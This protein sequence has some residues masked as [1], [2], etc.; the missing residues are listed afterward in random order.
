[1]LSSPLHFVFKTN[2]L[3]ATLQ[4]KFFSSGV[5]II[6]STRKKVEVFLEWS[7]YEGIP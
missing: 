2:P 5:P 6:V 7:L 3:P 4:L 1:M